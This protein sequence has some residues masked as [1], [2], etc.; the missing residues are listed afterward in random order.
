MYTHTQK[1]GAVPTCR[2]EDKWV[3]NHDR[4]ADFSID[5]NYTRYIV[6]AQIVEKM[7]KSPLN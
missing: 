4:F 2:H 7:A 1:V 5:Y 6:V 3:R